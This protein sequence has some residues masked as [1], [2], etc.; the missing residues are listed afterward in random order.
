MS[1]EACCQ[2][3]RARHPVTVCFQRTLHAG[4]DSSGALRSL[5][6]RSRRSENSCRFACHDAQPARISGRERMPRLPTLKRRSEALSPSRRRSENSQEFATDARPLR[7][8]LFSK[9]STGRTCDQ[10]VEANH[11]RCA[12]HRRIGPAQMAC[13]A[14][15]PAY[16]GL[17]PS[18]GLGFLISVRYLLPLT[19]AFLI[20][21]LA[22]MLFK[23]RDRRGYGPSLRAVLATTGVLLGKFAWDSRATVYVT[24]PVN[25]LCVSCGVGST[26]G[27]TRI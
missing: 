16:A 13:P 21:A 5:D 4:S 23:A 9:A 3:P 2:N 17:L 24:L 14:R 18:I 12:E 1:E 7:N 26:T 25:H 15:W 6:F 19:I 27:W 22:A 10:Q 8:A 11:L 20:V